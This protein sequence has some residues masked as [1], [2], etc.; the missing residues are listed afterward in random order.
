[1][2]SYVLARITEKVSLTEENKFSIQI[3]HPRISLTELN[4]MIAVYILYRPSVG[5]VGRGTIFTLV[6]YSRVHMATV[7][8]LSMLS[9]KSYE[10]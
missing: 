4:R 10:N 8:Y 7:V 9:I 3:Q 6:S 1:M 5:N 2:A